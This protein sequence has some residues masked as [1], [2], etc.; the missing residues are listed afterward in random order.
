M[1][2]TLNKN[3]IISYFGKIQL[4][5]NIRTTRNIYY[6]NNVDILIFKNS[7]KKLWKIIYIYRVYKQGLRKMIE[8]TMNFKKCLFVSIILKDNIYKRAK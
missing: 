5:I 4:I 6:I 8:I 1:C 7:Y 2:H 3:D